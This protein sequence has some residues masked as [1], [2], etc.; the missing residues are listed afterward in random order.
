MAKEIIVGRQGTQPA[1]ITDITVSRQHCKITD[2]GDGTFMLEGISESGTFV[3][4]RRIIKKIVTSDTIVQ[5]GPSFTISVK[6]ILAQGTATDTASESQNT[7]A[8]TTSASSEKFK[9]LKRI[10][11]DYVQ[12]KVDLQKGKSVS[13]AS[14]V[15]PYAIGAI[16]G[17]G[18]VA[19]AVIMGWNAKKKNDSQRDTPEQLEAISKKFKIMYVC[20][21]CGHFLGDN[22][23]EQ[24]VNR[25]KCDYCKKNW[26]T[27]EE[28]A[29]EQS[30]FTL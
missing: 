3:N 9:Q 26:L 29:E 25:N 10:Y 21:I 7:E 24:L 2:N 17:V 11:D 30:K 6:D 1:K 16:P 15:L 23:Y 27:P 18:G 8:V 20:P 22:P 28:Q 19:R 12:A 5:L 14:A 13:T 4:G